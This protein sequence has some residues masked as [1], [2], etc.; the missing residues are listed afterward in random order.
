[1]ARALTFETELMSKFDELYSRCNQEVLVF[2]WGREEVGYVAV[3]LQF[4]LH[5]IILHYIKLN[6]LYPTE[7]FP[8]LPALVHYGIPGLIYESASITTKTA[9]I[10]RLLTASLLLSYIWEYH[11]SSRPYCD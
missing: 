8:R 6:Y 5:Y 3:V 11:S 10:L 7:P 1:M 9:Q 4:T 2:L